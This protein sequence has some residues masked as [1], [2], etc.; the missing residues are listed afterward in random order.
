MNAIIIHQVAIKYI[1]V[2]VFAKRYSKET[3][4]KSKCFYYALRRHSWK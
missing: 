1:Y 4:R 2:Y 3:K